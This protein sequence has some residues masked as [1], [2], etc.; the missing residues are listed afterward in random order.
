[1][2]IR[3]QMVEMG[4]RAK[5]AARK[6][7]AASGK[8]KA[9]ALLILAG[10]LESESAA[11]AEAN[12]LDL[13]AAAERG[14]DK[15]RVQRLTISEKVLGSMIQGCREV[16]AMADPV[17]EIE[18]MV[19]RPNGMLVGR[20]RVPLGV[21]AMIYESRPNATVD[22]GILCL[23]AGNAVILRGGSEA[24][25]S[26]TCLA[27]LMH[28][29]LEEAGLPRD[30]VQVPPTTDREAVAEMLKLEEYIDVVIPRGGEGLIRA[31]T[32]QATMPVLKHYKGVCHIYA[33]LSCDLDKAVPI[34]ENAK[35]QYPSGCNALECL[36]VHRDVAGELLPRVAEAIGPKGVKFKACPQ[37]LPL[38]GEYAEPASD[39]DWGFEFL[40]LILAVK[41]V[42]GL[43]EA[44]DHIARYGSNHTESIL[45]EDYQNCMR[46]IREVDA[47]LVVANATTRFNDGG[48]L[49]LGAE[50]GISTSK[51]H[52]Y[53]PM[54]IKELTSA[55]FVLLGEGQVRE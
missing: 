24:F 6:L 41:V 5:A 38:L 42:D 25:H 12:K 51:L 19:K 49:G 17:G 7:S 11:I 1:M 9:D 53:G 13:D 2:D 4:K 47:S 20:M 39:E 37:S 21:V 14:L 26:N 28:R 3:E 22:A 31:V 8:A 34:V 27:G 32:S 35:M 52:A 18:S 23:K 55:K 33:D 30:A 45:S 36:L 10:L 54:G 43:D 46:F 40:D 44:M 50:I 15:A 48:Q 16:A 29:A